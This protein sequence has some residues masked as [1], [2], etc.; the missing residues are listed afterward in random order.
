MGHKDLLALYHHLRDSLDCLDSLL[1]HYLYHHYHL[2][3]EKNHH[4]YI[5]VQHYYLLL[6]LHL[7]LQ[8]LLKVQ[9]QALQFHQNQFLYLDYLEDLKMEKG[10]Y[11][12]HHKKR[13]G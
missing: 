8:E 2:F 1:L 4:L 6:R 9:N 11:H 12:Q 13:L 7:R 5:H 10:L 3:L